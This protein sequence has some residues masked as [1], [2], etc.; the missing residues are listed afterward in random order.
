MS[1]KTRIDQIVEVVGALTDEEFTE[2]GLPRVEVLEVKTELVEISAE[3]RNEAWERFQAEVVAEGESPSDSEADKGEGDDGE[4]APDTEPEPAPEP[5]KA[6][7]VE[8]AAPKVVKDEGEKAP[9]IV[10]DKSLTSQKGILGPGQFA[11]PKFF[12]PN[13]DKVLKD[14]ED[15]GLVVK[16]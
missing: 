4:G 3:E 2:S 10:G 13:G 14:L 15:K 6:A 16:T 9:Y 8:T 5:P 7:K 11:W 1:D 12:G